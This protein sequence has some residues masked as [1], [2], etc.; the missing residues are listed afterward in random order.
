[1]ENPLKVEMV[2][3]DKDD[4]LVARLPYFYMLPRNQGV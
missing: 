4:P 3:D 1:M 2:N